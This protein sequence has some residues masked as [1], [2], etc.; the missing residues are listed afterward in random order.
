[1]YSA[2][3]FASSVGKYWHAEGT[4]ILSGLGAPVTIVKVFLPEDPEWGC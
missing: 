3:C 4:I 2:V 1:M